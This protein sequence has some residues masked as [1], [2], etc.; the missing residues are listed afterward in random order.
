MKS[1]VICYVKQ[2]NGKQKKFKSV[3]GGNFTDKT[4]KVYNAPVL[5]KHEI[6]EVNSFW[7]GKK[8]LAFYKY[9]QENPVPLSRDS[10]WKETSNH[11]KDVDV[12]IS[13]T[14]QALSEANG[15]DMKTN[16]TIGM[17]GLVLLFLFV[18][19]IFFG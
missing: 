19:R 14:R 8:Q 15:Q 18:E 9:G 3:D 11:D 2:K 4:G 6:L 10:Q 12:L 17:V 7:G 13:V 5:E 16:I 1:S